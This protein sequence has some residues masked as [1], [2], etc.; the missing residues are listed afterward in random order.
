MNIKNIVENLLFEEESTY[1]D[2]KQAQYLFDG[3]DDKN[4]S[5]LLKDILAFANAWRRTDAYILIG[6]KEK[7]GGR[8]EVLGIDHHIDDAKIQQFVNQ[9]LNRPITFSYIPLELASQ[10]IAVITIPPQER[11]FF[12]NRDYGSLKQNTVYIRRGSST[13]I[14]DPD[15]IA[16]MGQLF[17]TNSL[18]MPKLHPLLKQKDKKYGTDDVVILETDQLLVPSREELPDFSSFNPRDIFSRVSVLD[19]SE[20]YKDLAEY[21]RFHSKLTPINFGI[22]NE[23]NCV[24]RD[25]KIVVTIHDPLKKIEIFLDKKAPRKPSKQKDL[26]LVNTIKNSTPL[27]PDISSNYSNQYWCITIQLGK[28][29][30][31]DT[32]YSKNSI[33]V[34]CDNDFLVEAKFKIFSDDLSEPVENTFELNFN[35]RSSTSLSRSEIVEGKI[36]K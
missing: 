10:K 14:A 12:L 33:Y 15:E 30:A 6:V 36:P 2:F 23:G 19:N 11:P 22:S 21:L 4:K 25:V 31:K 34:G 5:E 7:K 9:K 35:V 29:Q 17:E 8:S 24:A 16:R 28:I 32:I 18:Q 13:A 1:L 27:I 3:A 20:Y 26:S